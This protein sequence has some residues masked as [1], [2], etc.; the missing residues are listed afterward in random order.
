MKTILGFP[1]K[2]NGLHKFDEEHFGFSYKEKW[3]S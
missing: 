2:R 3:S 1:T